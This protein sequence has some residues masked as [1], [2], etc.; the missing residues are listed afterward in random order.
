MVNIG[1]HP[2]TLRGYHI[3]TKMSPKNLSDI[4]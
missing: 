1:S 2:L 3:T 4:L